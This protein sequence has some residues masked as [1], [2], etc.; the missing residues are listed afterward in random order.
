MKPKKLTS[1]A[2]LL[3]SEKSAEIHSSK[4]TPDFMDFFLILKNW[5]SIVGDMLA[6]N[7]SPLKLT[8]GTLTIATKHT[9]YS[10]AL[11]FISPQILQKIQASFPKL[12]VT[13]IKFMA[14]ESFFK[15]IPEHILKENIITKEH[16]IINEQKKAEALLEFAHIEDPELKE[17]F[18]SLRLQS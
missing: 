7:T 9:T 14:V 4:N 3:Q 16:I 8:H 10:H 13:Q 18:I 11:S 17:I 12:N 6:Q 15:V 1:F 5:P 2:Q